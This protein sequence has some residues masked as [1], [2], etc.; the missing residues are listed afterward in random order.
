MKPL[1]GCLPVLLAATLAAEPPALPAWNG[2]GA[3][4]AAME[5]LIGALLPEDEEVDPG[6][7]LLEM[8]PAGLAAD[9]IAMETSPYSPVPVEFWPAYFGE[10]PS[11][12][13]IDPQGLLGP[14]DFRGRLQFLNY[15]AEDSEIDLY[16]Y[17]FAGDQE[18]PG[19]VRDEELIERHF[20]DGRPAAVVFY[21]IG[22]PERAELRFS[23][24]LAARIPPAQRRRALENPVIQASRQTIPAQQFEAFLIQ[25]S[26]RLFLMENLLERE[27]AE[28]SDAPPATP[29][30]MHAADGSS[31]LMEFLGPYLEIAHR[32]LV[33]ALLIGGGLLVVACTLWWTRRRARYRF[34]DFEVEPRLGGAHAAG[35]GA[36]ISFASPT[37]PPTHHRDA[38]PDYL[39]RA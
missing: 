20:A 17:L 29:E 32:H 15:H 6:E 13:L 28:K 7:P 34:P 30:D 5:R 1:S 19:E 12:F 33:P 27:A 35:V 38:M 11:S 37:E 25:M 4:E 22:E 2:S 26:I 14:P 21:F 16:V 18:I 36:V 39:K 23:P 9:G 8:E 3:D 24:E 10:R 31:P